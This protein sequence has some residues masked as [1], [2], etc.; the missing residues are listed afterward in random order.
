[1]LFRRLRGRDL[2]EASVDQ[3]S[4][5][6]IDLETSGL[7]PKR[8][9]ILS[10]GAVAVEGG[11]VK[12]SKSLYSY[13]KPEGRF[14]ERSSLI[15]G[16]TKS[17]LSGEPGFEE[18]APR[19]LK[20]VEGSVLVGYNVSFDLSFLNEALRRHGFPQLKTPSLD[21]LPLSYGVLIKL[22]ADAAVLKMDHLSLTGRMSLEALA[23]LLSTP[24][25]G[26]HNAMG[27][28]LTTALIFLKLLSLAKPLG[29]EKLWQLFELASVGERH[30][31]QISALSALIGGL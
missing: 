31:K 13:V 22:R 21:V 5:I 24:V 27:D 4:F 14:E 23:S 15:H 28:A 9:G 29:V 12:L 10:I 3:A 7:S 6:S 11:E 16:I 30:A 25:I 20:M 8:N 2:L 1:L 19:L 17:Q 26:R 18:V